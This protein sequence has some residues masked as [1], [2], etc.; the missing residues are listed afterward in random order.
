MIAF[1]STNR[2]SSY[3]RK[4]GGEKVFELNKE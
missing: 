1:F 4:K 3:L 2:Y